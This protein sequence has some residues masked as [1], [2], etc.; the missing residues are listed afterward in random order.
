MQGPRR[1]LRRVKIGVVHK[2]P[3]GGLHYARQAFDNW[4]RRNPRSPQRRPPKS[5]ALLTP[6]SILGPLLTPALR[7][8]VRSFEVSLARISGL[9]ARQVRIITV[10]TIGIVR[11]PQSSA[12][13]GAH[14]DGQTSL[15]VGSR[16]GAERRWIEQAHG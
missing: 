1:V 5:G 12:D 2:K 8:V 10:A 16:S 9:G 14:C 7:F 6:A 13:D 4:C 3:K 15:L 11:L